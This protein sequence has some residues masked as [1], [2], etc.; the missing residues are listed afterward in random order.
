[1]V[2]YLWKNIVWS[3]A[4]RIAFSVL[5]SLNTAIEYS[6]CGDTVVVVIGEN[7]VSIARLKRSRTR[8]PI[9]TKISSHRT[10]GLSFKRK[11]GRGLSYTSSAH[12]VGS[13]SNLLD[14]S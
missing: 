4:L 10:W 1:M 12:T 3:T 14:R 11:V 5:G 13:D 9:L 8:R 2:K 7:L 6:G